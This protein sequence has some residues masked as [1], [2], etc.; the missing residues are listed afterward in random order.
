MLLRSLYEKICDRLNILIIFVKEYFGCKTEIKPS[1][2]Y[3][4]LNLIKLIDKETAQNVLKSP[5]FLIESDCYPYESNSDLY[6]QPNSSLISRIKRYHSQF[7][8]FY[9]PMASLMGNIGRRLNSW[10]LQTYQ[11][12]LTSQMMNYCISGI[13]MGAIIISKSRKKCDKKVR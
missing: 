3:V 10:I 11:A 9:G 12:K 6:V 13:K 8:T 1:H 4:I 2:I 7:Q 5:N